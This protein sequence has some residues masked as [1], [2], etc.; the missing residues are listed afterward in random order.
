MFCDYSRGARG[1]LI[2]DERLWR[3]GAPRHFGFWITDRDETE[4]LKLEA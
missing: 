1:A 3:H 4:S 2:A